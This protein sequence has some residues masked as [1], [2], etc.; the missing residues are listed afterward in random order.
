MIPLFFLVMFSLSSDRYLIFLLL[1][2]YGLIMLK[3][4]EQNSSPFPSITLFLR[5]S[6]NKHLTRNASDKKERRFD[7]SE[8]IFKLEESD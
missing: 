6:V 3:W 5:S 1:T 2:S 4:H 8:V 7:P